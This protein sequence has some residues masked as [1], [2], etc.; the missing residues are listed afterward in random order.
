VSDG[1]LDLETLLADL[2]EPTPEG[3]RAG[4]VALAGRPNVGK[5]TLV[6]HMVGEKVAIVTDVP[7]TTR[8]AI[9]GVVDRDDAQVVFLD[10]PGLAKPRSLLASRLNE[11]VVDSWQ[12]VDLVLFVVD[13]AARVGPG[14]RFIAERLRDAGVPVIAVANKEDLV[15]DKHRLLPELAELQELVDPIEVVPTA[16]STGFNCD[17]LLDLVVGQL[18]ESPRLLPRGTVTDQ[19]E[20]QLAAELVREAFISRMHEE[21]PHAIAV[22]VEEIEEIGDRVEV[23]AVV[24]VERDSQK[25]IVI[26]KGGR[27][28]KEAGTAAREQLQRLFGA[29]VHL[30]TRVKV[31]R[32]WQTDPKALR[33]LGY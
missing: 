25:G 30:D 7:G 26:G 15:T 19:A 13:V 4:M 3:F 1:P 32:N 23:H 11:L 12:G 16:A 14:D 31:T 9:R 5:S 22:V 24:H 8:N 20:H 29:P 6:N 17:V 21:L 28:I 2:D 33:R 27:T 18:P 10:T